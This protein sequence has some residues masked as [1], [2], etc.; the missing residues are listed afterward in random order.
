MVVKWTFTDPTDSS[1]YTFAINPNDG[2]SPQYKKRVVQVN[3]TAPNG[4][5]VVYEGADEPLSGSFSGV[6]LDLT[7][8]QAMVT[9]F[10]KRYPIMVEDDLG[11]EQTI[12]ITEF[13]PKRERAR[14]HPYKHSYTVSYVVLGTDD[15]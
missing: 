3:T 6:I 8:Y 1:V 14:S 15:L 2:G 4:N 10:S 13:T 12:Y 7:Q 9:W 5:V 11:R